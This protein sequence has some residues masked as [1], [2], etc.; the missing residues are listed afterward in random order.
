[1]TRLYSDICNQD[2]QQLLETLANK[3]VK[4]DQYKDTMTKIGMNLGNFLLSEINDKNSDVYLA[5]TVE[6]ADF[7]A[8]GIMLTLEEHLHNIGFACFWNQR[9]S[10]FEIEDLKVAPILKKYQEPAHEKVKYLI[11]IKSIISGACV[12]RTNL[13]NLIQKIEPE[14]IFIVA[15]VIY[16]N[17]EQKLKNE[18]AE[19]IYN[20]FKFF[21]FAK[22]DKRTEQGEVIPGIGGNVYLRLGFEGQEHKNEYIPEI[23]KMRRSQ[24]IRQKQEVHHT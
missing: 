19:N 13:V 5:C 7:L 15:P 8:K 4:P 1:M 16:Q 3:N 9:F 12:V 21:Y 18:F 24:F 22:D 6:D 11:V 14:K 23:V 10:P 20:K 17:A 2:I